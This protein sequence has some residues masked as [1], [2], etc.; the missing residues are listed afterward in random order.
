M[1][2]AVVVLVLLVAGAAFFVFTSK[3]QSFKVGDQVFAEWTPKV[4]Y[5][6]KIDK[7]CDKGFNVAYKDG[8]QRC[9]SAQELIADVV[10]TAN[11]VKVGTNVI[12][13][14]ANGPYY[15]ASV[16]AVNGTQYSIVYSDSTPGTKTL[17]EMRIDGRKVT[18]T[19]APTPAATTTPATTVI[20]TPPATS[21][22]T[23]SVTTTSKFKQGDAVVA[24]WSGSSW[25][26]GKIGPSCDQ[27]FMIAWSDGSTSSC[28]KEVSISAARTMTKDAAKVGTAVYGKWSGSAYCDAKITKV[29]GTKYNITCSDNYKKDNLTLED[30]LLK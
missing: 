1:L 20:P 12:A 6:G 30:L 16:T 18:E 7:T 19:V 9:V 22:T 15:N 10:P 3:G 23:V 25:Y 27:G 5:P 17:A 8:D 21:S 28:I 4:W 13:Q 29:V 2:I 14:W 11:Q 26:T 24:L